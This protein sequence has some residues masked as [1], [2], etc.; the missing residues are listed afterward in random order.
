MFTSMMLTVERNP[1]AVTAGDAAI[2]D[3]STAAVEGASMPD[4]L[5]AAL[6]GLTK[7]QQDFIF[8]ILKKERKAAR[9]G[10]DSNVQSLV[11]A[12]STAELRNQLTLEKEIQPLRA[13][14]ANFGVKKLGPTAAHR[15]VE[16]ELKP[17]REGWKDLAKEEKK[18]RLE[19]KRREIRESDEFARVFPAEARVARKE[20]GIEPLV[21]IEL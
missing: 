21:L 11:T 13:Q 12:I 5:L 9:P 19:A 2:F 17:F 10:L 6:R 4:N 1:K 18:S 16:V 20:A 14:L 15:W 8:H 3:S 7:E